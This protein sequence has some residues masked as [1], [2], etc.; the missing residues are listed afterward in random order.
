[1]KP[2]TRTALFIAIAVAVILGLIAGMMYIDSLGES[3]GPRATQ[4]RDAA[5]Q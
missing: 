3:E 2:Q 5:D 1:M 4:P